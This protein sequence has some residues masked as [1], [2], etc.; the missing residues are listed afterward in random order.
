[1]S[2]NCGSQIL[3]CDLP[4][5]FDTYKGCSHACRY[6]FVQRKTDISKIEKDNCIKS[7][8][9]FVAGNRTKETNFC[10]WDIPLHWGG[11]SD[12]FQPCE[13]VDRISYRALQVFARTKYPFVVSTKGKLIAE[14]EY[15]DLIKQ[16]NCVVQISMVCSKYDVL[17]KGAPT[18][19]ERLE[20]CRKVSKVAKRVIVRF[21]PY[22]I[23]VHK[24][25][26]ETLP[27]LK[28]AGV[29]GVTIEGMKF[30]KKKNGLVK[31]GGDFCY[32]V[33]K[34]K[35]KYQQIKDKCHELG[36]AFYC[37]ENRLRTMGDAMC[38][39]GVEGVEGFQTNK[40]NLIHLFNGDKLEYTDKQKEKDT[41]GCFKSCFQSA[42]YSQFIKDKTYEE[43]T[44]YVLN[45]KAESLKEIF[46][47]KGK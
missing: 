29:Y 46:G 26:L 15:L 11:M 16:C 31:V 21:Q 3:L 47:K 32:P 2:I 24:D 28:E 30:I 1:M 5:H 23:E 35:P 4:I 19:E 45:N 34:L 22:L 36:L 38:C 37:A 8:E 27:K 44:N 33:D 40:N 10:D 41:A 43:M 12:P 42:G 17:E 39:C 14:P 18:Y 9:K 7:L 20:M 25:I 6:C 13:K